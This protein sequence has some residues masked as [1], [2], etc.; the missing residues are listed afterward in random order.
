MSIDPIYSHDGTHDRLTNCAAPPLKRDV[1]A[2]ED[3]SFAERSYREEICE[4]DER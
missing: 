4:D 1:D 2:R 3:R